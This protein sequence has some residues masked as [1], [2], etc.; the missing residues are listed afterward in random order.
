M[1]VTQEAVKIELEIREVLVQ[2][3]ISEE[4]WKSMQA[5][6]EKRAM[7]TGVKGKLA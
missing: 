5:E 3:G 6:G 1:M 4:R 2:L 7:Q